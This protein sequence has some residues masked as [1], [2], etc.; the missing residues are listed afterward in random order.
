MVNLNFTTE[1]SRIMSGSSTTVVDPTSETLSASRLLDSSYGSLPLPRKGKSEIQRAYKHASE[2]FLTRRL[3]E[4]LSTIEPV[5]TVPQAQEENIEHDETPCKAPVAGAQRKVRAKIWVLYLTLLNAI[6]DLGSD[7][8][9]KSFGKKAW[10]DLVAKVQNGTIWDEVVEIG[11]GGI[12]GNLDADVVQSLATLL[13]AQSTSQK[14]NQQHLETYLSASNDRENDFNA[15][16]PSITHPSGSKQHSNAT[17]TLRDLSAHI[18]IIELYTLHVLPRNGEWEY[19][20]DFINLSEIL[21]EEV[22]EEL[23]QNLQSLKDEDLKGE[24]NMEDVAT[25]QE[26]LSEQEPR[27]AEDTERESIDTVRQSQPS[28][29]HRANSETDYG[30]DDAGSSPNL[31]KPPSDPPPPIIKPSKA[32]QIKSSRSPPFNASRKAA[33]PSVYSRSIAVIHGL[34]N[35]LSRLA[36]HLSRNP[37]GLLRF[38][39]FLM[40]LVMA[41]SRRDVKDRVGR[42]TGAG[43]DKVKRTVGM[44]VKVSYI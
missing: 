42:L 43:W 33:N 40:G 13:L 22:R 18:G 36:D 30:I 7:V 3:S 41:F 10:W 39:L 14:S 27:P 34:E 2:L 31:A 20:K 17:D 12:E 23:L 5:I 8:G 25:E 1:Y 28:S 37:M 19:A 9:S 35:I 38:V 44:G 6:A 32:S 29:H 11:Y 16:E 26:N 21:D 4:A 15:S 24:E